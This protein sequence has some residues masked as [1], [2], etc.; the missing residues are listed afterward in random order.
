MQLSEITEAMR[1][2]ATQ[3]WETVRDIANEAHALPDGDDRET[4]IH[5]TVDGSE[6]VIYT[7]AA[8]AVLLITDSQDAYAEEYGGDNV[9]SDGT[10]NWSVLAYAAMEWD[11]RGHLASLER[12]ALE[13]E[14]NAETE[15]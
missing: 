14:Q 5:E 13:M 11:V 2:I 12:L 3:Y 8:Q 15:A 10:I 4:Y 9:V 1:P 7:Y 6:W